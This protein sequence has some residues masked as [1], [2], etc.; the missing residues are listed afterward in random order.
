MPPLRPRC[1][2]AAFQPAGLVKACADMSI[3]GLCVAPR[4]VPSTPCE[5]AGSGCGES[6]ASLR[7]GPS[8]SG[9]DSWIRRLDRFPIGYS[10]GVYKGRRY[11]V[12][13]TRTGDRGRT[14]VLARELGGADLVSFNLY[15]TAAGRVH[16]KPCEMSAKKVTD[17]VLGL[18]LEA[19]ASPGSGDD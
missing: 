8:G 3:H 15:R 11:G 2:V 7:P 12:T 14:S 5:I 16:F 19:V 9:I 17:F 1:V 13:V 18:A 4:P 10:T 6:L